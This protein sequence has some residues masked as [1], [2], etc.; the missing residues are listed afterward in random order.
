VQYHLPIAV[1]PRFFG[2][3]LGRGKSGDK[4][5]LP[6]QLSFRKLLSDR[7]A[8]PDWFCLSVNVWMFFAVYIDIICNG[9]KKPLIIHYPFA[10]FISRN[11]INPR[12]LLPSKTFDAQDS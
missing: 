4:P 12:V 3:P 8:S 5:M 11:R 1:I 10:E 2:F 6:M 9:L 7:F